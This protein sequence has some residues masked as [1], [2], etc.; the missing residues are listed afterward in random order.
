MTTCV[1]DHEKSAYH[2]AFPNFLLTCLIEE[3]FVLAAY[4]LIAPP[5]RLLQIHNYPPL[6]RKTRLL[7]MPVP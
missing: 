3:L 6:T 5:L 7:T 1:G 4:C 2:A